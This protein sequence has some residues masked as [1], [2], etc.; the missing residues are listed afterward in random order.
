ME[1]LLEPQ[2]IE[3]IIGRAEVRNV[4][5]VGKVGTVA[6]CMVV[7]GSILRNTK[8]RLVRNQSIVYD[9]KIGSLKRFKDDA[10]EVVEGHECGIALEG[11]KDIKVGDEIISY[12]IEHRAVKL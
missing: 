1:G 12:K 10:K 4:F 3:K 2:L 6:G 8:I 11:F 5:S 7:N 9:G